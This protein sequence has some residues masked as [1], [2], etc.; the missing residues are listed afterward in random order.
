MGKYHYNT[1]FLFVTQILD[2]NLNRIAVVF[3][4]KRI[5]TQ[6]LEILFSI[7]LLFLLLL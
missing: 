7:F 1:I 4:I 6:L 3:Y 5:G 2:K